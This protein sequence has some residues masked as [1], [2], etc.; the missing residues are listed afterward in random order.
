MKLTAPY[1][2]CILTEPP[3][4]EE[5]AVLDDPLELPEAP[6]PHVAT[7]VGPSTKADSPEI[8]SELNGK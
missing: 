1:I 2:S 7:V 6:H 4:D 5:V 3:V 8:V